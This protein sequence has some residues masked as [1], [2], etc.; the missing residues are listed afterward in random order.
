M[1]AQSCNLSTQETDADD[2]ENLSQE[3]KKGGEEEGGDAAVLC[4]TQVKCT[5][6]AQA[7]PTWFTQC[8]PTHT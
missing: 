4:D 2:H 7:L 5:L 1:V 6:L 8:P 3:R